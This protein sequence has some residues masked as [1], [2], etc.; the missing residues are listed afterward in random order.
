MSGKRSKRHPSRDS[1]ER[2]RASQSK[3][4]FF[5]MQR[6]EERRWAEM[7]RDAPAEYSPKWID[8]IQEPKLRAYLRQ[9][10]TEMREEQDDGNGVSVLRD[11]LLRRLLWC[12]RIAERIEYIMEQYRLK[13]MIAEN[14][15]NPWQGRLLKAEKYYTHL[16]EVMTDLAFRLHKTAPKRRKPRSTSPG[17]TD[18]GTVHIP[19][20]DE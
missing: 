19:V 17:R 12:A 11:L 20:D 6:R 1:P 10:Y 9:V 8:V 5:H 13:D 4:D 14:D 2:D 7:L 16:T 18:T 3:R 15:H